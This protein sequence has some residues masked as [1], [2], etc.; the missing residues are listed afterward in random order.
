MK[1]NLQTK[2]TVMMMIMVVPLRLAGQALMECGNDPKGVI[3]ALKFI[4]N[5]CVRCKN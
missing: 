1:W 4:N 3:S 2:S 5:I